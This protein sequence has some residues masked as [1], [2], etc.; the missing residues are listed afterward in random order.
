VRDGI[1]ASEVDAIARRVIEK[2][3]YGK[4]FIHSTGHGVGVEIHENPSISMNSKEILKENMVI[5]VEPGIYIKGRYGIRIEDTVIVT[6]GKPIVL[7][8]AYKLL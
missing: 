5:T 3:G 4:Y 7:E 1:L 2:T 8:T 6:K